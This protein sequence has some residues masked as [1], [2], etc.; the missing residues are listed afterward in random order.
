M[1]LRAR[2]TRIGLKQSQRYCLPLLAMELATASSKR[3]ITVDD[4][5]D[6]YLAYF[7]A[8]VGPRL[9]KALAKQG[10]GVKVNASK[11]RQIIRAADPVLLRQV[12]AEHTKAARKGEPTQPLYHAMVMACRHKNTTGKRPTGRALQNIVRR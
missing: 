1:G 4:A 5:N 9:A 2:V 8:S 11:L 12:T 10:N 7:A 3:Q 6:Y